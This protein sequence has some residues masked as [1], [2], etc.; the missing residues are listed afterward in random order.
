MKLV[1]DSSAWLLYFEGKERSLAVEKL[2]K[3]NL[4]EI[5]TTA[6]NLYEVKYLSLRNGRP[7]ADA[8]VDF[9]RSNSEIIPVSEELAL[10][11]AEL[12]AS[13]GLSA[14]DAFTLAAAQN[15]GAKIVSADPHFAPFKKHLM[16]I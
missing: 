1:F 16:K 2:L 8:A 10:Q 4:G 3:D 12:R 14:V 7:A 5:V 11:A 13:H 9:I 15:L 6:A